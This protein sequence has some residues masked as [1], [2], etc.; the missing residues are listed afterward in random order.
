MYLRRH[1]RDRRRARVST[2]RHCSQT[3]AREKVT[4]TSLVPTHY[5]MM[6]GLP[7]AVKRQHDVGAVEQAAD[8]LGAGAQGHQARDHGP[9]PQL[10]AC[11]NSTAPPR[12]AGSPCCA[13]EEQIDKLG[14]VG[15]EWAG[16]GAIRLLDPDGNEVPDGEVGE[17]FSRT[18]Y[19]FD[20]Y[21]KNP[22]K[23]AEA[24]RGEWCS[25]GD[26]A[27]RD[28]RRL[29][30]SRRPEEQHDHQ[31]RR[32]HLPVRGRSRARRAPESEG[33]GGDRRAA[34]QMGRSACTRWWCCTK[35][36]RTTARCR[37]NCSTGAR[38][39]WPATSGRSASSSSRDADMPRTATGKILHR[40]LREKMTLDDATERTA[41][42]PQ[43]EF[44]KH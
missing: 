36:R 22:E 21:W 15:R 7:D 44:E 37:P 30:P 27:R 11:S 35:R 32:E 42:V 19:V 16:S 23:T 28:G 34:R 3:L 43:P 20:G 8:L 33:R 12:P 39:A 9:L 4:F 2:R 26:M 5:I 29:H 10:A 14:S 40:T 1:H 25:V 17:L 24:F 13:R 31:R 38:R 41:P 18:A 6:L